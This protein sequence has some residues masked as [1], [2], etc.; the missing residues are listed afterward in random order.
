VIMV[1]DVAEAEADLV[2]GRIACPRC[3]GRLRPWSY[4]AVRRIRLGDGSVRVVR[5]RRGRCTGCHGTQVLLP[6]WCLPRRADALE[7]VVAALLACEDGLGYRRIAARLGRSV[8]TVRAWLRRTRGGHPAWLRQRGVDRAAA[9]DRAVLVTERP[10]ATAVGAA[11]NALGA[12]VLA[13]QRRIRH[14]DVWALI[15]VFTAGRL[16]AAP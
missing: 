16:L 5:P 7:V 14:A 12:A 8:W 2:S 11:L 15:G 6:G 13:Y 9:L 1:V 4:A 10:A 3:A